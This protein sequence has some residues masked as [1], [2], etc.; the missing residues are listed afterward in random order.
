MYFKTTFNIIYE[1]YDTILFLQNLF[2][3][4]YSYWIIN[5]RVIVQNLWGNLV[6]KA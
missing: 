2:W 5:L 4:L 6:L 3:L 1:D